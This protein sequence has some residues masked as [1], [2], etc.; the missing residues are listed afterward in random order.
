MGAGEGDADGVAGEGT[1]QA[2]VPG[3]DEGSAGRVRGLEL[4]VGE[5]AGASGL[6]VADGAGL[7]KL[8]QVAEDGAEGGC[9]LVVVHGVWQA[10]DEEGGGACVWGVWGAWEC[11]RAHCLCLCWR[12][13]V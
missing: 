2:P 8:G 12:L 1:A 5:A 3:E 9:E 13:G 10:G 4:D 7:D 6:G 11:R